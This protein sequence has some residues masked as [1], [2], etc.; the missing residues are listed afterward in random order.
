MKEIYIKKGI[1]RYDLE[2][3]TIA[4][5]NKEDGLKIMKFD[6]RDGEDVIK[7]IDEILQYEKTINNMDKYIPGQRGPK[8]QPTDYITPFQKLENKVLDYRGKL[9]LILSKLIIS[10]QG[11]SDE[12]MK[13]LNEV[14]KYIEDYDTHFDINTKRYGEVK[15]NESE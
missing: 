14:N 7:S 5:F 10:E 13:Q 6:I 3:G 12:V 4:F 8:K 15:Q 1:Y 11:Y 2:Y 9:K